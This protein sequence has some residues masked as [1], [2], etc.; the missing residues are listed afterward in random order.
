MSHFAIAGLQLNL[1]SRGNLDYVLDKIKYTKKRYPFVKMI[2]CSELAIC[3]AGKGFAEALK[4]WEEAE[5][6]SVA[7]SPSRSKD[8]WLTSDSA[9]AK[10]LRIWMYNKANLV[11]EKYPEFWPAWNGVMLKLY[12]DDQEVLD[13]FPE[14]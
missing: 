9:K 6:I 12:R 8:W 1:K 4:Y 5:A 13:Y 10:G 7:L 3:G 11:I 2:V 14:G